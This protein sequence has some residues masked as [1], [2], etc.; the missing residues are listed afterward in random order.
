MREHKASSESGC[1][2]AAVPGLNSGRAGLGGQCNK[3]AG[4]YEKYIKQRNLPAHRTRQS[5]PRCTAPRTHQPPQTHTQI[6]SEKQFH[7]INSRGALV[8]DIGL[9]GTEPK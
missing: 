9:Q 7:A 2:Q 8:L 5:Q 1:V 4:P 3:N 6:R